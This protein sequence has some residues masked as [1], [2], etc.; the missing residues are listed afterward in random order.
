MHLVAM[1]TMA[2]MVAM[3]AMAVAMVHAVDLQ[4]RNRRFHSISRG[5]SG[6]NDA[7]FLNPHRFRPARQSNWVIIPRSVYW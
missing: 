2:T 4:S 7:S 3:A 5:G 1:A 6:H